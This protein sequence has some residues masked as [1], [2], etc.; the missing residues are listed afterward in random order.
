[1]N[2]FK[3]EIENVKIIGR[4]FEYDN[5]LWM[6]LSGTGIE[7]IAYAS[8]CSLVIAGDG[9]STDGADGEPCRI[10]IYV[11][12]KLAVDDLIKSADNT[13]EIWK[14]DQAQE[15]KVR[16]IKLSEAPMSVIG[17][18]EI[19]TDSAKIEP[20]PEK[21]L[22]ME[23]I[24]DSITCGYG[25]DDEDANHHFM[26][27]TEN[28]TK[29]Y[30]FLTAEEL[31]ADYSMVSYSGYGIISGYTEGEKN[32]SERVPP[33]YEKVAFTRGRF[34]EGVN[35]TEIPWNFES[36]VP[37]LIVINLGTNDDSYC[38]DYED[39]QKE[40]Q[41]NYTEFLK[42]VR[43]NNPDARILCILGIMGQR[44]YSS[45][46]KAVDAYKDETKDRNISALKMDEQKAENG[47]SADWHPS[48]K[49][50]ILAA[51]QLTAEIRGLIN[52]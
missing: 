2:R 33:F 23:F 18:K 9:T 43:K 22:K 11:N 46:E 48:A 24:G 34:G 4:T 32:T 6:G 49:T 26:T 42:T 28:I 52:L 27:S 1:M 29:S 21:K 10:A 16:L 37:N 7:F 51:K 38:K 12:G 13:Y 50:H 30:S 36:F 14:S 19:L 3:A 35:L 5:V 15:I 39:R 41:Q 40:Y 20:V 44:L 25:T 8:V 17:V 45:M 47:F 31:G